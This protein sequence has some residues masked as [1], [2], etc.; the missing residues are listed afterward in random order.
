MR[1][2]FRVDSSMEIGGGH[3]SR[4]LS[5]AAELEV[6]GFDIVFFCRILS[7]DFTEKIKSRHHCVTFESQNPSEIDCEAEIALIATYIKEEGALDWLI[8]DHYAVTQEWET[9]AGR[10]VDKIFVIDDFV[11]RSHACDIY[12]NQ[13]VT[14]LTDEQADRINSVSFLLGASYA[15]LDRN[16]SSY[17]VSKRGG[18]KKIYSMVIDFGSYNNFEVFTN[19]IET[20]KSL[21]RDDLQI[22]AEVMLGR[23]EQL[24]RLLKQKFN[25]VKGLNFHSFT[26]NYLQILANC[27]VAIGSCGVTSLE[28]CCLGIPSF[29]IPIVDNQLLLLDML[30]QNECVK[31]VGG[32]DYIDVPL[33]RSGLSNYVNDGI[34]QN[35]SESCKKIVDGEGVRRVADILTVS[36]STPVKLRCAEEADAFIL[37][38]WKNERAA[39]KYSIIQDKLE[40]VSHKRWLLDRLKDE[41]SQLFILETKNEIPLGQIRF[42][43]K[44]LGWELS[45]SID[46]KYRNN[47]LGKKII[48]MGLE[49]LTS[50]APYVV[51]GRV[52][53]NN[54][55]SNKIFNA[56]D[57]TCETQG[58]D[59]LVYKKEYSL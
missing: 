27:D 44:E 32:L 17:R 45:Y 33:L 26:T 18:P 10:I 12:L 36:R 22:E 5:L 42:D 46:S 47:G 14:N 34:D 51:Y 52:T 35:W 37:F 30:V 3:V 13:S 28:R 8:I 29:V 39:R 40:F 11:N 4:C 21:E 48:Q 1:I 19:V 6:R 16:I 54:Q 25:G 49:S 53:K 41:G 56:L 2:G 55:I 59:I 15:L 9:A 43:Y 57:F 58:T 20:V 24:L 23:N 7:G 50:S 31:L 38:E